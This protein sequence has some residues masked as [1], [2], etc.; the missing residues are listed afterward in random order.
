MFSVNDVIYGEDTNSAGRIVDIS[1]T[2]K[3]DNGE[4]STDTASGLDVQVITYTVLPLTMVNLN[5]T[6]TVAVRGQ[7]L[8]QPSTGAQGYVLHPQ[9]VVGSGKTSA[10][11][12]ILREVTGSFNGTAIEL[13]NNPGGSETVVA[14]SA[15]VTSTAAIADGVSGDPIVFQAETISN[16]NV[17]RNTTQGR[18]GLAVYPMVEVANASESKTGSPGDAS[19]S[20]INITVTRSEDATSVNLQYQAESLLDADV[21]TNADIQQQKL[22]MQKAP[23]LQDS[24]DFEDFT[25]NG[26][27][28]SQ[29]NKGIAAFSADAFAEDQVF[30]FTG[31]VSANVGDWLH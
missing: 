11:Q 3:F 25:T 22:L 31:S 9:T 2:F 5:A 23:V 16:G 15:L 29:A 14:T 19:R 20:D 6:G 7:L 27:R 13:V 17:S 21:N 18:D 24:D 30:V 10:T 28:V 1:D 26:R 12:M 8:R 4:N